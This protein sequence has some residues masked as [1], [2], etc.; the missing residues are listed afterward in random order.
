MAR[1]MRT[2]PE[3]YAKEVLGTALEFRGQVITEYEIVER[4]Q[5]ADM[6]FVPDP[7]SGP[8]GREDLGVMD[9]MADLGQCIIE[10]FSRTP[11]SRA[12]FDCV[13]KHLAW[14]RQLC[15]QARRERTP[16]PQRPRLW[17]ISPGRP[18][19]LIADLCMKP[20][21]DWPAG[22]WHTDGTIHAHVIVIRDLP[23][24][25]DTLLLRLLDRGK[26]LQQA[27]A[28]LD[29]LPQGSPL[30]HRLVEM[31]LAWRHEMFE[32]SNEGA[33]IYPETKARYAEWKAKV[34]DE[35]MR[36]GIEQGLKQGIER[37]RKQGIER[38]RKQGIERGRKQGI[39]RGRKQGEQ[40]LL[41]KQL[42]LRF[43]ELPA[44]AEK[45]IRR[46]SLAE[47]ELWAERVLT[48]ENLAAVFA[49]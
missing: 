7:E 5:R 3:I 30:R 11:G 39:E 28:E 37:G 9:S 33:M 38:G 2:S 34:L 21:K 20:M 42:T 6:L 26:R 29:E 16:A 18:R 48:A 15:N 47:L 13:G 35:G 24:T 49:D 44:D 10:L 1:R 32:T 23:V 8:A 36:K 31:M 14:H 27:M 4:R 46:A 22:F 12:G 17:M 41:R 19:S 40:A 45:R 43:G 25:R